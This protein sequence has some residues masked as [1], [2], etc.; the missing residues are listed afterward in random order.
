[1]NFKLPLYKQED[2]NTCALACL[3]MVL[4]ACGTHIP[5]SKIR[6]EARL[7]SRGTPIDE[8]VRLA[9]RFQLMAEIRET[10][11]EGLGRMLADG[12]LPIAFIDRKIFELSPG[13]RLKHSIRDATIHNVIPIE[14]TAKFVT[15]HDP[16]FPRVVRRTARLFGRAFRSLGGVCVVCS[17]P[18]EM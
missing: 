8:L 15:Y 10:T 9:R 14:V 12:E 2:D 16:L 5:E 13:E 11:V 6:A 1:M 18:T 17:K 7:E 4:A 3:R